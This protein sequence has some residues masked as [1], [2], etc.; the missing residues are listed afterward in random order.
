[1]AVVLHQALQQLHHLQ[2][3]GMLEIDQHVAAQDEIVGFAVAHEIRRQ[4]I[5]GG[6][7]HRL[8]DLV[9]HAPVAILRREIRIAERQVAAAERVAAID[10]LG[11]DLQRARAD[12]DGVDLEHGR[13]NAGIEQGHRQRIRLFAGRTRQA[14]DADTPRRH[15]RQLLA[16]HARHRQHRLAVAE[17][18]GFRHHRQFDQA[19]QLDL[20]DLQVGQIEFVVLD[21]QRGH[22]FAHHALDEAGADGGHVQ[23]H[24]RLELAGNA[25]ERLHA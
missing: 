16:R 12:I 23:A 2:L 1:M 13:R 21:L 14:E 18:P 10:A 15:A 25:M 17:E 24:R 19:L 9:V 20:G 22:A 7:A 8:L 11:G 4:D 3:H 6:E 5:A